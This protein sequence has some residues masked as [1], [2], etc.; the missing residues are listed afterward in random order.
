MKREIK[1]LTLTFPHGV[2]LK[3]AEKIARDAQMFVQAGVSEGGMTLL[4]YT[5]DG[6]GMIF[7]EDTMHY[8]YGHAREPKA[9]PSSNTDK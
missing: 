7:S 9:K 5:P 3:V 6:V 8:V 4:G 2:S 1:E